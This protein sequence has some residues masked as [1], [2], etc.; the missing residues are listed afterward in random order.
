[1]R[2]TKSIVLAA[3]STV[4]LAACGGEQA[5]ASRDQIKA[6]GSST[7]YPF[8]KAAA[9]EFTRSFPQYSSPIIESTGTGGGIKLFCAGVGTGHP[10]I[11]NASRRMKASEFET[12]VQ[13]G[14]TEVME[15]EV[16][17]DGIAIAE[18]KEGQNFP[19]TTQQIYEALA[20]EPYGKP[21]T[22]KNW[23]DIDPS[24]P[25]EP[26]LV[27]GPPSTSGTRDALA[28]LILTE[29]C[30]ADAATAALKESDEDRFEQICT[31][32]RSDGAYVEQGENDNLIV[33]KL[34]SNPKAIGIF[35][36]SFLEENA[37]KLRGLTIN[38]SEP[39]YENI[40]S[41][42]YPGARPLFIYVKKQHVGAIPGLAEYLSTW[43]DNW[44][45]GGLFTQ[46]G[47]IASP[48]EAQAKFADVVSNMTTISAS[49]LK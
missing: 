38:G 46:K 27:Y 5:A 44:A 6:V 29:G 43:V 28:E 15:I 11:A 21:N 34:A 17:K 22:T 30:K 20:K 3:I 13:N 12:C 14:V 49:D 9:E 36:Y 2:F 4:A 31:E 39:T 42:N 8:A 48:E 37:D 7:V 23:S 45:K 32:V 40:A 16:G 33:Q 26:I 25:N 18:S 19:L 41:D 1:M 24:L 35:G 47:M 10:D